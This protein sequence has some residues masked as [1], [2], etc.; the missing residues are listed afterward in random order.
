MRDVMLKQAEQLSER[1]IELRRDFH[2]HPE[3]GFNEIRTAAILAETA[4]RFEVGHL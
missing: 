2:Q 1:I 4:R 3:L